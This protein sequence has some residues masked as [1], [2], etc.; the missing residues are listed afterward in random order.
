MTT[1]EAM[2]NRNSKICAWYCRYDRPS[3]YTRRWG[4][5]PK[6][7]PTNPGD[8]SLNTG[9]P[10]VLV[11]LVPL[12]KLVVKYWSWPIGEVVIVCS[13]QSVGR[14]GLHLSFLDIA[15]FQVWDMYT[16]WFFK[17]CLTSFKNKVSYLPDLTK[18]QRIPW[19]QF[20]TQLHS[21]PLC[22]STQLHNPF[23][24]MHT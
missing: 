1:Y 23:I 24:L 5:V 16:P 19:F 4:K 14:I 7:I 12:Q 11:G 6:F 22:I 13:W 9:I 10:W 18:F 3:K 15:H 8:V 17:A 2:L 21:I 20:S